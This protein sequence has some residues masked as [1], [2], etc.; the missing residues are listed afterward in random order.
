MRKYI[1]VYVEFIENGIFT[2]K[3]I[4]AAKEIVMQ[5]QRN[6]NAGPNFLTLPL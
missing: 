2:C 6:G 1:I 4:R 3:K 5:V